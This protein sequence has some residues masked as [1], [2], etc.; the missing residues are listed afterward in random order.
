MLLLHLLVIVLR[1]VIAPSA[2]ADVLKFCHVM[3]TKVCAIVTFLD[4]APSRTTVTMMFQQQ[5][6]QFGPLRQRSDA[7]QF[8]S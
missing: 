8:H 3:R 4:I 5:G 6:I 2:K 1:K 7:V